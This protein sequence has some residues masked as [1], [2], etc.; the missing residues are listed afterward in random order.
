MSQA[1]PG[2]EPSPR[3]LTL[4]ECIRALGACA[5]LEI[6]SARR[7]KLRSPG[8]TEHTI[9][10][11]QPVARA[12]QVLSDLETKLRTVK[13]LIRTEPERAERLLDE[14]LDIPEHELDDIRRLLGAL[15]N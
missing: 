10:A 1:Y 9:E 7:A 13:G 11:W 14:V 2:V 4:G 5:E 3:D 12:A 8:E 15:D 6:G